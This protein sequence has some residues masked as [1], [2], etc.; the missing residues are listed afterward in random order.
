[1]YERVYHEKKKRYIKPGGTAGV[2]VNTALVP[3]DFAETGVF[4]YSEKFLLYRKKCFEKECGIVMQ[5]PGQR[6]DIY[7]ETGKLRNASAKLFHR[8][9]YL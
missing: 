4:L 1:M 3:A 8:R 2:L 6:G 5:Q 9:S 7:H